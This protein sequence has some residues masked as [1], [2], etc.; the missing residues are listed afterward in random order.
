MFFCPECNNSFDITRTVTQ[1]GGANENDVSDTTETL[2]KYSAIIQKISANQSISVEDI[3]NLDQQD[4]FKSQSFKK[5]KQKQRE[6]IYNKIQDMLPKQKKKIFANKDDNPID[7]NLAFFICN[8]CGFTKKIQPKTLIFS[9]ASESISQTYV[10]GNYKDMLHS[11]ILPRT[12]RYVCPNA[13][14]ISHK[15]ADKREAVF[16]RLNNSYKVKYIC[17]ACE[18]DF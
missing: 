18:T 17:Q 10:S 5:L 11:D 12:R 7:D 16:F 3:E 15:D 6:I 4:L 9:R 1:K 2:D 8:N 14:C 13:E